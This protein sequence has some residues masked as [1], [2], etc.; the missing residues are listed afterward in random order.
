MIVGLGGGIGATRLWVGL[1][2][3]LPPQELTLIVNT[4]DDMT[5]RGLR[6]C[7]DIDT[8]L[9]GLAGLRDEVRGWGMTDESWRVNQR[10]AELDGDGWFNLGDRDLATHLLRSG[11]RCEGCSP[12]QITVRLAKT[13]G[14]E[15]TI[16]PMSDADVET[17]VRTAENKE[18]HFQEYLVRHRCE[19]PI[20][21]L[22]LRGIESARAAPGVLEAIAA[23]RLIVLGPSNPIAS[24]RPILSVPGVQEAIAR[25]R[26]Y[27]LAVTPTVQ[28]VP[29]VDAGEFNR[30]QC[31]ARLLALEG[32]AHSSVAVA[33]LY[34]GLI[35]AF[36]LDA[37]DRED[38]PAIAALG[39][40]VLVA[41]TLIPQRHAGVA[42]A[43][44]L[45]RW[46]G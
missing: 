15:Q 11:L 16:L 8:T 5:Y 24:L 29:I 18:M 27:K 21:A 39:L 38:G 25:S 34:R 13:L 14:L 6:I 4:A 26:A 30:A 22:R 23:A 43:H 31:R 35:D 44:E 46:T 10:L 19:V 1:A 7:P 32:L 36:V 42:L 20:V 37:E 33:G 3:C 28:R 45:L 12:T 40:R 17:W 9:Y 2:E 41:D